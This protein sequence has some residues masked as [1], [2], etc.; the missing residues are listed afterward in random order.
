MRKKRRQGIIFGSI[1]LAVMV[2]AGVPAVTAGVGGNRKMEKDVI[3]LPVVKPIGKM[4]I[5]QAISNRRSR[6]KFK[7]KPLKQ[8][9]L[10]HILWAAQGITAESGFR[11]TPSAGATFPLTL[12]V[13][14]GRVDDI[15]PGV[16]RYRP[17]GH[18]LKAM[19]DKDLRSKLALRALGQDMIA[20]APVSIVIAADYK[21]T[22]DRY[23]KRGIRYVDMEAGHASQNIYLECES[24]GLGT[25]AVGAFADRIVKELLGITEDPLY[26]MPI[27][28]PQ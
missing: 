13:V 16:Y 15:L 24:L 22:T 3:K 19:S 5:E 6:R 28:F 2:T 14:I 18:C 1:F 23:G 11:V 17:E 25:C 8:R 27:G 4:S 26:I 12:Y 9:D 10:S 20:K 7:D 21:R